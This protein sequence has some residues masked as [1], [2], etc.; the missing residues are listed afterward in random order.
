[1]M[2]LFVLIEKQED[3]ANSERVTTNKI[4]C[5]FNNVVNCGK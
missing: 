3:T 5:F 4:M 1:M 2:T